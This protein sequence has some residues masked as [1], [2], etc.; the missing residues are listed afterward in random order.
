MMMASTGVDQLRR[1]STVSLYCPNRNPDTSED[2]DMCVIYKMQAACGDFLPEE[3]AICDECLADRP[4]GIT[5]ESRY[6]EDVCPQCSC[7]AYL[8]LSC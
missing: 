3:L 8:R 7:L 5:R 1:L 2:L 6:V 4:C